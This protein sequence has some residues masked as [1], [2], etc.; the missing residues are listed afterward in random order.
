MNAMQP[1]TEEL[2][3]QINEAVLAINAKFKVKLQSEAHV[4][5]RMDGERA[6]LI[7]Y[8]E[9]DAFGV[10]S[11]KAGFGNISWLLSAIYY[12]QAETIHAY[13]KREKK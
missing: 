1:T 10:S 6:E 3:Q 11:V 13:E 12:G 7:V 2:K 9:V 4:E 5:V 8:S